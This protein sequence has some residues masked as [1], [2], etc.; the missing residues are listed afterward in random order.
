LPAEEGS[1]APDFTLPTD[2]GDAIS[3]SSLR[4][5]PVVLYSYPKDD[6]PPTNTQ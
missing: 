4:G 6:T 1:P 5:S 3:L 2:S